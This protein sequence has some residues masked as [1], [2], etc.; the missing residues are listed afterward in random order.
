MEVTW[1]SDMA[2]KQRCGA[3]CIRAWAIQ[4]SLGIPVNVRTV[5]EQSMLKICKYSRV[6]VLYSGK[7]L[8]RLSCQVLHWKH[9]YFHKVLWDLIQSSVENLQGQRCHK[10]SGLC[11]SFTTL[12]TKKHISLLFIG[13]SQVAA[14]NCCYSLYHFGPL[15]QVSLYV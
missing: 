12:M 10:L 4:H 8:W 9:R 11:S 5:Y 13:I 15:R 7:D 1:H 14:C 3:P 2:D 6:L